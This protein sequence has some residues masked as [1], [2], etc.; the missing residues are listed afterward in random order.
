MGISYCKCN[1]EIKASV[2]FVK[3]TKLSTMDGKLDSKLTNPIVQEI[4]VE[5]QLSPKKGITYKKKSV[6]PKITEIFISEENN[7]IPPIQIE[8][9]KSASILY[10]ST[11]G[12]TSEKRAI[13]KEILVTQRET[14]EDYQ[15]NNAINITIYGPAE[16]GKTTFGYKIAGKSINKFYIPSLFTEVILTS[17]Q[18][19]KEKCN[20][21]FRIP[22]EDKIFNPEADCCFVF[23]DL[24]SMKSFEEA[25]KCLEKLK[26][27]KKLIFL[28]GNKC[29]KMIHVDEKIIK[30]A[31]KEYRV[32]YYKISAFKGIGLVNLM[33]YV[34][35]KIIKD[36]KHKKHCKM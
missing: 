30:K 25:K 13:E 24:G 14:I 17:I 1:Q 29:D 31:C 2:T 27:N 23:F 35:K 12:E 18:L 7:E 9:E 22:V 34:K 19:D 10:V 5:E 33:F 32:H 6:V 8:N 4:L 36:R 16:S 20:L 15:Q 28:I 21:K 26:Q 11:F 3:N